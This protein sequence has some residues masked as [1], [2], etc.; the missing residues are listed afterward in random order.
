MNND[1]P[2][3]AAYEAII[4]E[5]RNGDYA[6]ERHLG[7]LMFEKD[8]AHLASGG[9]IEDAIEDSMKRLM[10]AMRRMRKLVAEASKEP[11]N[12][13]RKEFANF[14]NSLLFEK[15]TQE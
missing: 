9:A 14:L 15:P 2:F 12:E 4:E 3:I 6:E 7:E 8:F 1:N 11:E 13:R 5:F 10:K